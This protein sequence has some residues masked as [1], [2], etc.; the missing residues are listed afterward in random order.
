MARPSKYETHVTPR[1][2]E[3]A[4]WV[5]NGASDREIAQ[6]LNIGKSSFYGFRREFSEFSDILKKT[7]DAVDG[8]VENAL[9]QSALN[10]NTTAQI[11]WLKNRRPKQWRDKPEAQ[12]EDEHVTEVDVTWEDASESDDET[13]S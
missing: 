12:E 4:D 6:R 5:R 11:F 7:R 3:I 1:L 9:L 13:S 8:E 2:Q 10:G